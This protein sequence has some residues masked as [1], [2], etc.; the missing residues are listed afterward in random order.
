MLLTGNDA[1]R[2]STVRLAGGGA[3]SQVWPQL[4]ADVLRLPVEVM[5]CTELGAQGS[6]ICAAAAVGAAP[7]YS[8][9][10]A[11]H[12]AGGTQ[13]RARRRE[14]RS[15]RAQI[16]TLHH[17]GRP[18]RPRL[19]PPACASARTRSC[20]SLITMPHGG[21]LVAEVLMQMG[22]EFVFGM[23]GGQTTA[24]HEGI[25]ARAPRIRHVLVRDERSGP[26]AADAY[27]RLTGK[28]GITDVT[29]GPGTTKLP[30]GLV[31]ALNAS[32]PMIALVG[33]LPLDW[34]S[35]RA[36][37]VASQGF[38][39]QGFLQTITKATFTVPSLEALPDLLRAAFRIATAPRPGPVALVIPHDVM[40]G[41]WD[42]R[43]IAIDNRHSRIP[44][45]RYRPD[46]AE[47]EAAAA[48]LRASKRA[49]FRVRRRRA[50][51]RRGPRW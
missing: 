5:E 19:E 37:G 3:R 44:S 15:L 13:L 33:E 40:D 34:T 20:R 26:Y 42:G 24:L 11:A 14:I 10:R 9:G 18:A 27:A 47:I 8:Y 21:D 45:V 41:E 32:I 50:W 51:G 43:P 28:P 25:A 6:A 35:L 16:R 29:V 48:L 31:E 2:P 4:F 30:D 17:D 36:K 1:A 38:D 49:G 23:P 39:Q 22:V 7:R 46:D 12:D